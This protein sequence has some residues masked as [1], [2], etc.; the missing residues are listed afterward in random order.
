MGYKFTYKNFKKTTYPI[1]VPDNEFE[2]F[3]EQ[4]Y[5]GGVPYRPV[6][7][8]VATEELSL[9]PKGYLLD[10]IKLKEKRQ[11]YQGL[12][13]TPLK[14]KRK[15]KRP[16]PSR[17]PFDIKYITE[18]FKNEVHLLYKYRTTP[19]LDKNVVQLGSS[20]HQSEKF[21][22]KIKIE[23]FLILKPLLIYQL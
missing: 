12:N 7:V 6:S 8:L 10:V 16:A 17:E 19:I 21:L 11:R 18:D 22:K 14:F 20:V 5:K 23:I 2:S 13:G 4:F 9:A 15:T 1:F 3:A